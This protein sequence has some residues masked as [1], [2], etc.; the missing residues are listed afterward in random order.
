MK[1]DEQWILDQRLTD[2]E[3]NDWQDWRKQVEQAEQERNEA[4]E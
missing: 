1:N 4:G 3:Y 2:D